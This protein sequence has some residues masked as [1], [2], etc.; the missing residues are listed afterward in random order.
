MM[1]ILQMTILATSLLVLGGA[2]QDPTYRDFT[3]AG[4]G[5]YGESRDAPEP[6]NLST[7]KIGVLGPA[8]GK[9]GL[10]QRTAVEIAVEEANSRGGYRLK[11]ESQESPPR[12]IPFEMVFR[13]DD[14]P[15]GVAASQVVRFAYEDKVWAIIGGLDGQHTHLAE[16]VV[17]KAWVPVISPG[18][19]DSSIDYANVPWVFR[20]VTAD[21]EQVSELLDLA[22]RRG[23][24]HLV[25]LTEIQ[26]EAYT[27]YLRLKEGSGRRHFTLEMHLEYPPENPTE[28]IPRIQ[29]VQYDALLIWGRAD[30]A[31]ALITGLRDA[32]VSVPILGP[33][34]LATEELASAWEKLGAITVAAPCDLSRVNPAV[35][36][37]REKFVARTGMPPSAIALYSYDVARLVIASIEKAGLNRARI[38]DR[39]SGSSFDGLTGKISFNSLGGNPARPVLMFLERNRWMPLD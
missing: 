14:G 22:E 1:L 34:G 37:F 35:M 5:F 6:T 8:R 12:Q 25:V 2:P 23:Y 28:I 16:L 26:R 11:A 21:R 32:G 31:L 38:R 10:Q 39:I 30:S 3:G 13:E 36:E 33:S 15:W 24:R 29:A 17:S 18:A 7:V 9:E 4:A 20:A 19:T 27:G